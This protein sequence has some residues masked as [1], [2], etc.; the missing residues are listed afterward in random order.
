MWLEALQ[1]ER[2]AREH[3]TFVMPRLRYEVTDGGS[4][5]VIEPILAYYLLSSFSPSYSAM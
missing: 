4:V 5:R 2:V 3:E 1:R